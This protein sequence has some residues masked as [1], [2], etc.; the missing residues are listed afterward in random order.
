MRQRPRRRAAEARCSRVSPSRSN[1][2]LIQLRFR[3]GDPLK[4]LL[5]RTDVHVAFHPPLQSQY[6]RTR[7]LRSSPVVGSSRIRSVSARNAQ[8]YVGT[9]KAFAGPLSKLKLKLKKARTRSVVWFKNEMR[10]RNLLSPALD[11]SSLAPS[12]TRSLP[13]CAVVSRAF[14]LQAARPCFGP[15]AAAAHPIHRL[16]KY[17]Y[18]T[19]AWGT[20]LAPGSCISNRAAMLHDDAWPAWSCFSLKSAWAREEEAWIRQLPACNASMPQAAREA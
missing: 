5:P 16:H 12:R 1:M 9:T 8:W 18:R 6:Q 7:F 4:G 19:S 11:C 3:S 17:S 14:N 15:R 20:G 2:H 13:P 10:F